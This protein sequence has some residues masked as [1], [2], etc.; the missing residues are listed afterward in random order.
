MGVET[1]TTSIHSRLLDLCFIWKIDKNILYAETYK[2]THNLN[3]TTNAII[4]YWKIQF[5][6][7][8]SFP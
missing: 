3:R 1:T 6:T 5:I 4:Y 8:L 7:T 2:Y